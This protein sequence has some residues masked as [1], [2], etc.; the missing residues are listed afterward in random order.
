[1]RQTFVSH[2]CEGTFT[3]NRKLFGDEVVTVNENR[4]VCK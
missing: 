1:M 2:G 3:K 4:N